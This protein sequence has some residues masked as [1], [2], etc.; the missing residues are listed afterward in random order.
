M[1][2]REAPEGFKTDFLVQSGYTQK[3][4]KYGNYRFVAAASD[5]FLDDDLGRLS[6]G[7]RGKV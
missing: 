3:S 1:E 2:L 7:Q 4:G 6:A 5:R